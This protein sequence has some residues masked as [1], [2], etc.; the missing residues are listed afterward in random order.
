M[1]VSAFEY[2]QS[3]PMLA[4]THKNVCYKA[5]HTICLSDFAIIFSEKILMCH[6]QI[7]IMCQPIAIMAYLYQFLQALLRKIYIISNCDEC[8]NRS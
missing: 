1:F 7:L 3:M 4:H 2:L 6:V 8:G 5:N